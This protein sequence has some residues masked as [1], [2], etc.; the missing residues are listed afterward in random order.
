MDKQARA[1]LSI[2]TA[3]N[4]H[5]LDSNNGETVGYQSDHNRSKQQDYLSNW[6]ILSLYSVQGR[7]EK[8]EH[9]AELMAKG[10]M[11]ATGICSRIR[12]LRLPVLCFAR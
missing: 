5:N 4:H 3:C 9:C 12:Y 11:I 6:Y 7:G 1:E 8:L 10:D 2:E